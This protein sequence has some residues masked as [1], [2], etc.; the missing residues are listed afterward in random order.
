MGKLGFLVW[1]SLGG[2]DLWG[3]PPPSDGGSAPLRRYEYGRLTFMCFSVSFCACLCL[4]AL[5]FILCVFCVLF[6]H[7]CAFCAFQCLLSVFCACLCMF[8]FRCFSL[9]FACL[10]VQFCSEVCLLWTFDKKWQAIFRWE[11]GDVLGENRFATLF[12]ELRHIIYYKFWSGPSPSR[13]ILLQMWWF[14]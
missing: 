1:G 12:P 3:A 8:V 5:F 13:S 14:R 6:V 9:S 4:W 2:A 10:F 11:C 7:F